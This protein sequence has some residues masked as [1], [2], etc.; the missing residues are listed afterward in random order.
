MGV[1]TSYALASHA[2]F[3]SLCMTLGYTHSFSLRFERNGVGRGG[4]AE[5]MPWEGEAKLLE[6]EKCL[7]TT[8]FRL[9]RWQGQGSLEWDLM[10]GCDAF[11]VGDRETKSL[12]LIKI[13]SSK[14]E[15]YQGS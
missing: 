9:C 5:E 14:C 13:Q 8:G 6:F 7:K 10:G 3:L 11:A 2:A 4:E 12:R 15:W 1:W